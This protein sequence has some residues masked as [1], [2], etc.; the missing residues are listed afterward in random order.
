MGG[1]ET[2]GMLMEMTMHLPPVWISRRTNWLPSPGKTRADATYKSAWRRCAGVIGRENR[3]KYGLK[4]RTGGDYSIINPGLERFI[5][6]N[7]TLTNSKDPV[8]QMFLIYRR[9]GDKK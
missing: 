6:S 8:V 1:A 5:I 4:K 2:E 9:R 7:I 3:F